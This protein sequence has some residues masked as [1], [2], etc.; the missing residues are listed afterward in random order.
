VTPRDRL[1][2]PDRVIW[3]KHREKLVMT[4]TERKKYNRKRF[5]KGSVQV[6]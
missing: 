1:L 6:Y 3:E 5:S 4:L 2:G